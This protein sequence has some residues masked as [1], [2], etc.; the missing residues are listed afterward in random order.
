MY[1]SND[2]R[3]NISKLIDFRKSIEYVK[4]V[5][6]FVRSEF[7]V[8]KKNLINDFDNHVITREIEGGVDSSN[9][10]G[11]LGGRGN[12]FSFIGFKSGDSPTTPIRVALDKIVLT[13]TIIRRDGSSES[14]ALYPLPDEIFR[15]TP[16]PWADG[17]SWA[18]G[19]EKGMSNLGH[20]LNKPSSYSRSGGGIQSENSVSGAEFRPTPYITELIRNFER[21]ISKL[22]AKVI[23]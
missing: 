22:G 12:L 17:R 7:E 10:S 21:D 2:Q 3:K 19:I 4:E 11:T 18:E 1:T 9:I 8:V 23:I 15:I 20:F 6:T 14:Y 5:K 16:L 13:Q